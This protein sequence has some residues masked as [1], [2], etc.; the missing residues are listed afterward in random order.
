MSDLFGPQLLTVVSAVERD[1]APFWRSW[2]VSS[3]VQWAQF[4]ACLAF[5]SSI[6]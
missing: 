2:I 4:F 6:A 5:I 3:L 1:V